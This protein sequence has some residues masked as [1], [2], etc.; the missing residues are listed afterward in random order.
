MFLGFIL[1]LLE[2][3]DFNEIETLAIVKNLIYFF[4]YLNY[5]YYY[6]FINVR[7]F[8]HFHRLG[9]GSDLVGRDD[10]SEHLFFT[11]YSYT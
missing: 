9:D 3:S 8:M 6:S 11:Q 10:P 1:Q 2:C 4:L 7:D 5:N